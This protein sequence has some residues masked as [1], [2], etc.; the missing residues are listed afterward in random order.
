MADEK[1][2]VERLIEVQRKLKAPKGQFN[3]FAKFN[4]RSC[5][6]ITEAVKPLLAEQGL[7]LHMTDTVE[8][9]GDRYYIKAEVSVISVEKG[10]SV[11][12]SGW[13]REPEQKKG[14]DAAQVTGTSSSYA[15][16]Y[17]LNGLF[18]IDDTKDSDAGINPDVPTMNK[19]NKKVVA[20]ICEE[21]RGKI[22]DE[23]EIDLNK[24]A[25]VFR[26]KYG[27]YP[28]KMDTVE[29]AATWLINL[30][31]MESWATKKPTEGTALS[32]KGEKANDILTEAFEA[33]KVMHD[34]E[35]LG[36]WDFDLFV[37]AAMK[38]CKPL[39]TG[40]TAVGAIVES[41]N[42]DDVKPKEL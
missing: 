4:Y 7:A 23:W 16:K 35:N 32:N 19:Q 3:G 36:E 20:A 10:H 29:K 28:S 27:G 13:A 21:V 9:V 30:K 18:A 33:F 17:A 37:A 41:L 11:A 14:M 25:E 1:T 24:V 34:P 12:T 22:T 39:P 42:V 2:V 8:L 40:K 26:G 6:D 38:K 5:E 15:R 31:N